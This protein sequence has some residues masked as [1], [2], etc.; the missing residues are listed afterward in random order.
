MNIRL[1]ENG[2]LIA[3]LRY[4]IFSIC[5]S[6]FPDPGFIFHSMNIYTNGFLPLFIHGRK[7]SHVQINILQVS[8]DADFIFLCIFK[9]FKI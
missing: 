6:L 5:T 7:T 9:S 1:L 3:I 8:N 2:S 4:I